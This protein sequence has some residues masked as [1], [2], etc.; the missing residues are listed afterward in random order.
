MVI[1][2]LANDVNGPWVTPNAEPLEVCNP[3]GCECDR[4]DPILEC[5]PLRESR[6][7]DSRATRRLAARD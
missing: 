5:G 6:Q 4:M 2:V 7:P 3:A 1:P